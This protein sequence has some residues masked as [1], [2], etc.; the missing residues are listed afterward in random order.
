MTIHSIT[1]PSDPLDRIEAAYR[2][3]GHTEVAPAVARAVTVAFVVLTVAA[4]VAQAIADPGFYVNAV[5]VFRDRNPPAARPAQHGIIRAVTGGNRSLLTGIKRFNDLLA[6]QSL[7]SRFIRPRAQALLTGVFH[8]GTEQ[9]YP[10][11][12]GWLFYAPDVAHVTGA[13]FLSPRRLERRAREGDTLVAAPHPDPRIAIADLHGYLRARGVPLL[14]LPT[15]VKPEVHGEQFVVDASPA[16]NPSYDT[17]VSGLERDGVLVLDLIAEL[18]DLKREATGP[19]YLATDTHWRP[20]MV[21]HVAERLADL[22]QQRVALPPLPSPPYRANSVTITNHGDTLQLLNL[23]AA[24]QLY[25]PETVTVRRVT[26]VAESRW[27][28]SPDADVLLLGDSF[29]NIYSLPAMGWG[30]SAG[31]AEQ[32]SYVLDRPV[33]RLSQNDGGAAAPRELLATELRRG[34]DR[35]AGKRL[36]VYQFANRELSQGDWRP[37]NYTLGPPASTTPGVFVQPLQGQRLRVRGV[38]RAVGPIPVPR[39]VPYRDHIVGV[40]L[41][42]LAGSSPRTSLGGTDALVYFW[43]MQ[44]NESTGASRYSVGDV[45]EVELVPWAAV[46]DNLEGISRSEVDDPTVQLAEP[47]WG[48]SEDSAP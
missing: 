35:L 13:G 25:H 32:L 10:G 45:I 7:T 8:V 39:S 16:R 3:V 31:L 38:V 22:I 19:L 28:P 12:D 24:Q 14:V 9:V 30:D 23:A 48:Q 46:A 11:R 6:E 15:P 40:H 33:D 1:P 4:G 29:T 34:R 17:F 2:E 5:A 18:E 41:A 21:A 36:V 27:R 42:E 20:E 37:V 44:D 43:S 26:P 47:W